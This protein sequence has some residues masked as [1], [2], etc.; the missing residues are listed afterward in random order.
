[1]LPK[2]HSPET[3]WWTREFVCGVLGEN[4]VLNERR[5]A[6]TM[7]IYWSGCFGTNGKKNRTTDGL[8][9]ARD[10][11]AA[12]VIAVASDERALAPFARGHPLRRWTRPID[13]GTPHAGIVTK[14][15]RSVKVAQSAPTP[16]RRPVSRVIWERSLSQIY[17]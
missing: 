7:S 16:C 13:T 12:N 6:A 11:R 4:E 17:Y 3:S 2:G 1:M 14:R 9:S 15:S 10:R 5:S 8:Y